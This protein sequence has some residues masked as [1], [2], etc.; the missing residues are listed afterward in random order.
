MPLYTFAQ[1]QQPGD[2][3]GQ[4]LKDVGTWNAVRTGAAATTAAKA[5]AA[6]EAAAGAKSESPPAES[7]GGYRY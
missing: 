1:D 4:G 6:P 5:P 7:S 3:K 2:A